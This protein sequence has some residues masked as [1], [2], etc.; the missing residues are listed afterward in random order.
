MWPRNICNTASLILGSRGALRRQFKR[1]TV[2]LGVALIASCMTACGGGSGGSGSGG[3]SDQYLPVSGNENGDVILDRSNHRLGILKDSYELSFQGEETLGGSSYNPSSNQLSINGTPV[4]QVVL[5]PA[6]SGS[7]RVAVFVCA[8]GVVLD[9][10]LPSSSTYTY[11]C[12]TVNSSGGGATSAGQG[13]NA[14]YYSYQGSANDTVV[15]DGNDNKFQVLISN[16]E[17]VYNG[18]DALAGTYVS[19]TT[20]Q[21]SINGAVEATIELVNSTN[22]GQVAAF[23]CSNGSYLTF[24]NLGTSQASATCGGAQ[25][26]K[27]GD[28]LYKQCSSFGTAADGNLL[29][30]NVCSFEIS[31][32]YCTQYPSSVSFQCQKYA[33]GGSPS[34]Y[35]YAEGGEDLEGGGTLELPGTDAQAGV[36]YSITCEFPDNPIIYGFTTP[37]LQSNSTPQGVCDPPSG[38]GY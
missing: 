7:G 15:L 19:P 6:A 17:V 25:Q 31:I 13:S 18:T 37:T 14:T 21:L 4:A 3:S 34:G 26:G 12:S 23:V 38:D 20:N 35:G 22:N 11:S 5:E 8:N 33:E 32:G 1:A 27:G 30:T 24:S 10:E 36:T 28:P 29:V 2:L 16:N 9:V